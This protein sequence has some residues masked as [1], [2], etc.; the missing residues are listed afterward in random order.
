MKTMMKPLKLALIPLV[1][2]A[3]SCTRGP[4]SGNLAKVAKADAAPPPAFP[5]PIIQLTGTGAEL[6]Q[7][8][9]KQLSEPIHFLFD[10]YLKPYFSS[11]MQRF[12]ALTAAKGFETKLSPEH[13]DEVHGL[14]QATVLDEREVMLA[15][16]F[17]DLSPMTACSTITLP[18]SA[19]PDHIARFGR[20]L[21]FSS[22]NVADK[23]TVLMIYHPS[24]RYAFAAISWPGLI[25]VL[26]GMNE[27]GLTVANMEVDR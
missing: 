26:S 4:S 15:Q 19:A 8:H 2:L 11:E 16:C 18:A 17:L 24:G 21:D 25:G 5:V 27:H 14:S 12:L 13:R 22:M 23:R 7:Q 6:G 20:N 3:F 1:F 9:G 10:H